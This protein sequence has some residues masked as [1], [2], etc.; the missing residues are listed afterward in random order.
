LHVIDQVKTTWDALTGLCAVNWL[1][2]VGE[3]WLADP[4][5]DRDLD[6]LSRPLRTQRYPRGIIVQAGEGPSLGD[7]HLF[8][9]LSAYTLASQ[10]VEPAL[11]AEPTSLAGMY[12]DHQSTLPWIRR[13][14]DPAGWRDST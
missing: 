12:S 1:T 10:A 4:L 9:D 8:D 5:G 7:Q 6:A 13:F 14:L 11:I 3:R 2:L